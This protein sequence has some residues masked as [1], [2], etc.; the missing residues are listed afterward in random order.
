MATQLTLHYTLYTC[1]LL[2]VAA[3]AL[4]W[5]LGHTLLQESETFLTHKLQVLALIVQKQPLDT[6]G[7]EQE[8]R[9][10]AEMPA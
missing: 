4:Y 8:V 1:L 10:E 6:A 7:L 2:T 3:G 9:D 5:V